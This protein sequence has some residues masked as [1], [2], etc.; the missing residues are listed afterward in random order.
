M[1]GRARNSERLTPPV[2]RGREIPVLR[3]V[4]SLATTVLFGAYATT[5]A[6]CRVSAVA[7]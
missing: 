1:D 6:N 5:P 7:P 4:H 2:Q 3:T